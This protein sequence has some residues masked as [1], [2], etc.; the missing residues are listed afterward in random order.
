MSTPTCGM[1][2]TE[3]LTPVAQVALRPDNLLPKKQDFFIYPRL[4]PSSTTSTNKTWNT[5]HALRSRGIMTHNKLMYLNCLYYKMLA[6][7]PF[8][9]KGWGQKKPT[10]MRKW[11]QGPCYHPA[12]RR[13]LDISVL[14]ML[15]DKG[16]LHF[17]TP[18]LKQTLSTEWDTDKSEEA[19]RKP[20]RT[21][22]L[23][24]LGSWPT[25]GRIV[26]YST[27]K[28]GE[29]ILSRDCSKTTK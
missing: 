24:I 18:F 4:S 22:G 8:W 7:S 15:T 12:R 29:K 6:F 25:Y 19:T 13:I 16:E 17:K 23:K 27:S 1:G 10:A 2:A 9:E 20:Q 3:G 11:G 14:H 26:F 21:P 28:S 5:R